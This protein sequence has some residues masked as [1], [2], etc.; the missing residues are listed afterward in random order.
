MGVATRM[1]LDEF[2]A[3]PETEPASEFAYGRVIPPPMPTFFHGLV[4]AAVIHR[5]SMRM[6]A[7]PIG[8]VVTRTLHAN[9]REGRAYLPDVAVILSQNLPHDRAAL[10][11]GP[12]EFRPDLAI[13]ILSPDDRPG[14]VADKLAFYLRTGV[15]L[16]WIVDIDDRTLTAYRP[17]ERPTVYRQEDVVDGTPVLPGLTLELSRLFGEIDQLAGENS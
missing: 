9:R 3:L 4:T 15:P 10:V 6:H 14:R 13:E 12:L 8:L 1:T 5:L 2:L 11:R 17:G 16:T 7:N